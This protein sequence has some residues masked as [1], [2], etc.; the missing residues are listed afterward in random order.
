LRTTTFIRE[1]RVETT[2][3]PVQVRKTSGFAFA[4][5]HAE[6]RA[7]CWVVEPVVRG[8]SACSPSATQCRLERCPTPIV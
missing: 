2:K 1:R 7:A 6:F 8:G 4:P 5:I 3:P